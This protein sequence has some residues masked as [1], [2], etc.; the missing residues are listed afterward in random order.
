MLV[1][2]QKVAEKMFEEGMG[3][4]Y[5]MKEKLMKKLER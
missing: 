5:V 3:E 2:D 4:D 1:E